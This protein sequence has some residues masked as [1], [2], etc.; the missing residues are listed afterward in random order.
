MVTIMLLAWSQGSIEC[1]TLLHD[2]QVTRNMRIVHIEITV[3]LQQTFYSVLETGGPFIVCAQMF[4]GDLERNLSLTLISAD[5]NATG[6]INSIFTLSSYV[7]IFLS[8]H[9]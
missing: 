7:F 2:T 9:L 3:G 6:T 1:F 5:G 4:V 8:H